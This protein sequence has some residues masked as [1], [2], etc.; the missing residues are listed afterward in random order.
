MEPEVQSV[1]GPVRSLKVKK[2]GLWAP[3]HTLPVAPWSKPMLDQRGCLQGTALNTS[4]S[5]K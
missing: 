3:D 2:G 4:S 1:P 5:V